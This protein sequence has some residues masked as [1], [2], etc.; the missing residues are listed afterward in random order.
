VF[1]GRDA[2]LEVIADHLAVNRPVLVLGE[3]GVGKTELLRTAAQRSGRRVLEAGGLSTLSWMPYL[4]LERAIGHKITETDAAVIA[5]EIKAALSDGVLIADDLQWCDRGTLSV[6]TML[7]GSIALLSAARSTDPGTETA[8]RAL[9]EASVEL[10][11]LAPLSSDDAAELLRGLRPELGRTAIDRLYKRTGGNPLLLEEL[12]VTEQPSDT[13]RLAINARLRPLTE[14]AGG[15]LALLSVAGR[16]LTA[17]E[18]SGLE[19][20]VG[21][22]LAHVDAGEASLRHAL[23][24]ELVAEG[25]SEAD[26]RAVHRTLAG[27]C[28]DDAEAAHHFAAAGDSAAAF[29]TAMRASSGDQH[30]HARAA[31]LGIAVDAAR[32]GP[33][34]RRLE[35]A[36]ALSAADQHAKAAE[37]LGDPAA[38]DVDSAPEAFLIRARA[39]WTSGDIEG[40]NDDVS[41]GLEVAPEGSGI[42][43]ELLLERASNRALT[44]GASAR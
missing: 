35:A 26:R 5:S 32:E 3:A 25:L 6:L 9:G 27:M 15:A 20:L 42:A 41:A 30:P 37:V 38:Y 31:L 39:R 12:A 4:P 18:L 44:G 43:I 22:G 14:D 23:I 7:S 29:E 28:R 13:L 40:A 8:R 16:P 11:E 34:T 36:R 10:L 17:S 2:E 1:I 33:T 19:E 21:A 24:G